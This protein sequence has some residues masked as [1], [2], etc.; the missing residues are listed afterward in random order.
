MDLLVGALTALQYI[1]HHCRR[2]DEAKFIGRRA[3]DMA[4]AAGVHYKALAAVTSLFNT[5][6]LEGWSHD[7]MRLVEE[8]LAVGESE[9]PLA[10]P[11][12]LE[13][14]GLHHLAGLRFELAARDLDEAAELFLK[15]DMTSDAVGVLNE[16][17]L[18]QLRLGYLGGA[19]ERLSKMRELAVTS[20]WERLMASLTE[21]RIAFSRAICEARE[22]ILNAIS[23][24]SC[25]WPTTGPS[26]RLSTL[27]KSLGAKVS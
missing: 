17:V 20:N 7:A 9:Y 4:F 2:Y 25:R 3:V 23:A 10:V 26:R 12:M 8:M 21:G 5:H 27:R 16:A 22:T 11:W 1:L 15:F 13:A 19:Q 14:R 18:C 24:R 6:F